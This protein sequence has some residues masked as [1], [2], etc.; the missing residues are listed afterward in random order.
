MTFILY[1]SSKY[2]GKQEKN[3]KF[4]AI[5]SE[6]RAYCLCWLKVNVVII[7]ILRAFALGTDK[8]PET[9]L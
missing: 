1:F 4:S 6:A 2:Q 3:A 8:K 5:R 9:N 7:G